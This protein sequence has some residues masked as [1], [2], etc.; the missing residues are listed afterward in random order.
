MSNNRCHTAHPLC[1]TLIFLL[2]CILGTY[3]AHTDGIKHDVIV[4]GVAAGVFYLTQTKDL[5]LSYKKIK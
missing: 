4:I 1:S 5:R 2:G 3:Y